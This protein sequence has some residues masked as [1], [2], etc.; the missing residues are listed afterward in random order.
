[1]TRIAIITDSDSSLPPQIAADLGIHLVPI[2]I[3]FDKESFITG[4]DIDDHL[5]FEKV[6]SLQKL[7]T[8]SSPNPDDFI[9]SFKQAFA[10]GADAV[11][12][13]CVSSKISSTYSSA[14]TAREHFPDREIRVID[15]LDLTMG[16][17]F[18]AMAAAEAALRNSDPD[19]IVAIVEETRKKMHTM[20]VLPTLKYL[21]LGG[22]V[23]K[24]IASFADAINIKPILTVIDGKLDLLEKV[25]TRKKAVTRMLDLLAQKVGDKKIE[26]MAI[27]HADDLEGAREME[28]LVRDV[29]KCP[30]TILIAE[31]TPGLSVHAGAGLVA[32]IIQA[33]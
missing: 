33:S 6:D 8:T 11:I 3:H 22:R 23:D 30:E 26:R 7:P 15:S 14:M 31:F 18:M 4:L 24:H 1:M 2:G 16:Q 17:G 25:R 21:A 19:E 10:Q 9:K 27:V 13:I 5:L 29:F 28:T 12:C 20:G 32:V